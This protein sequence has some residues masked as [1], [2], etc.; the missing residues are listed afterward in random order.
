MLAT[1]LLVAVMAA[2][3]VAATTTEHPKVDYVYGMATVTDCQA[4]LAS[5]TH[6]VAIDLGAEVDTFQD[7][8]KPGIRSTVIVQRYDVEVTETGFVLNYDGNGFT[9]DA[10]IHFAADLS[11]GDVVAEVPIWDAE[12]VSLAIHWSA[13][14]ESV[15]SQSHSLR[16]SSPL[17]SSEAYGGYVLNMRERGVDRAA[18]ATGTVNGVAMSDAPLYAS[19]IGEGVMARL[20]MRHDDPSAGA[21]PMS[22][23]TVRALVTMALGGSVG[24]VDHRQATGYLTT[25]QAQP[26]PGDECEYALLWV[27]TFSTTSGKIS[28]NSSTAQL[29]WIRVRFFDGGDFDVLSSGVGFS[30]SATIAIDRTLQEGAV[31]ADLQTSSCDQDWNC[32]DGEPQHLTASWTGFGT[33]LWSLS[34]FVRRVGDDRLQFMDR[35][36]WRTATVTATV[37]N[38]HFDTRSSGGLEADIKT[39]SER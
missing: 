18:E 6:C 9:R 34:S 11:S 39:V 15:A 28:S 17:E 35:G 19:I 3:P 26:L 13:T 23:A 32:S 38:L 4:G 7:S 25:C 5:G 29:D 8:G 2:E 27:D 14:S 10:A 36:W 20:D 21:L 33:R 24:D 31:D 1:G 22:E 16:V 12:P 30:P 37:G